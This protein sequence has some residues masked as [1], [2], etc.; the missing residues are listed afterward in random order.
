MPQ[1]THLDWQ[2][3]AAPDHNAAA[4]PAHPPSGAP[5]ITSSGRVVPRHSLSVAP[6]II[7]VPA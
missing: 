6:S 1:E 4:T 5:K 2:P 7:T 3:V